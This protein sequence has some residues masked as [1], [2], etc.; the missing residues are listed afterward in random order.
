MMIRFVV[1]ITLVLMLAVTSADILYLYYRGAWYDPVKAIEVV[2][3]VLMYAFIIASLIYVVWRIR[4]A[5]TE[6]HQYHDRLGRDVK[7]GG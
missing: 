6:K 3:I 1:E 7:G 2:E 4:R 5:I